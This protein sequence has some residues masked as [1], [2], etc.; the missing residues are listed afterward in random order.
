ME[1]S[2]VISVEWT[3][4][5]GEGTAS[6]R[7][8]SRDHRVH[9]EGKP[10]LLASS[11]PRFRGDAQRYNPEELLVAA[12]S[13][14]HMLWYLHLCADEGIRVVSYMDHAEGCMAVHD[15]GGQFLEAVLRPQVIVADPSM[16]LAATALH[17]R[18]NRACYIASS[19]SFRVRHEPVVSPAEL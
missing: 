12:L 6:Y 19:V 9:A 2:Y 8:Y 5:L 15:E 18:A 11:D 7:S 14:C 16:V 3:G 13:G 17:E 4:N 1:H 10:P